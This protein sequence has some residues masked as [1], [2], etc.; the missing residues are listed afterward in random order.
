MHPPLHEERHPHCV[1]IIREFKQCQQENKFFRYLGACNSLHD[2]LN[3]CLK[4]QKKLRIEKNRER[5]ADREL[6]K[7]EFDQ[8]LEE[9]GSSVPPPP[10]P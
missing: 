3:R 2:Q 7:K 6:R 4:E 10:R 1:D 8:A 9:L 5:A